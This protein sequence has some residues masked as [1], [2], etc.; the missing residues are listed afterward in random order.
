MIHRNT[1][2]AVPEGVLVGSS[3]A[4]RLLD[5]DTGREL[6]RIE[7]PQNVGGSVWK[8]MGLVGDTLCALVGDEEITPAT[9][10]GSSD[11]LG[12]WG[13]SMWE[14]HDYPDPKRNFAFGNVVC[15]FDL[16]GGNLKWHR[17]EK[18]FID[19]RAICMSNDRLVQPACSLA[20][21]R[22]N[23][24]SQANSRI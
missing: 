3:T 12:H 10:R 14:G 22:S 4:C 2:I 15:A 21:A 23:W 9:Q 17:N 6:R 5:R 18:S 24:Y 13:W 11:A 16:D 19:G 20:A 8:W 1:W 7:V